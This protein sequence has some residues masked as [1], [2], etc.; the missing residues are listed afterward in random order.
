M[1]FMGKL[2]ND[3]VNNE[4]QLK[5]LFDI[6]TE[7]G[8]KGKDNTKTNRKIDMKF[9]LP[10]FVT[11]SLSCFAGAPPDDGRVQRAQYV[12]SLIKPG[13]IGAEI[14]VCYGVFAYHVLLK[15]NPSK[16]YLIDPWEYGLQADM[17]LN[18]TAEKQSVKDAQY[19]AVCDYFSPYDCVEIIRLK[20]EDAVSL[21]ENDYFNYVYIDGEHSYAAVTRDLE[22]YFPK[23]KVN[24][25]LIG[26]DYGWTGIMPAVQDF[27]KRHQEECLFLEDPYLG[28]T[29]GQFAIQ[30][31]Q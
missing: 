14:G 13:D 8:Y 10:L 6:I 17:E 19:Y 31:L 18:P 3:R 26:D 20:S 23:V 7:S 4:N 5:T 30:R 12:S 15:R 16:L 28:N 29:G 21:F 9:F 25:Y 1:H 24:G 11:I 22:N 2:K 27:L